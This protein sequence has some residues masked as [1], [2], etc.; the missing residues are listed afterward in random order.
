MRMMNALLPLEGQAAVFNS[1]QSV[2][3]TSWTGLW[4]LRTKW[5]IMETEILGMMEI[6]PL[7]LVCVIVQPASA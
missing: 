3:I 7:L 1:V 2:S 4:F 5:E 6:Q